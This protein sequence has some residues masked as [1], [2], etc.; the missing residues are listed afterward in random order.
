[1]ESLIFL[2]LYI[3]RFHTLSLSFFLSLQKHLNAIGFHPHSKLWIPPL[4]VLVSAPFPSLSLPTPQIPTFLLS[5]FTLFIKDLF[6]EKHALH[7]H[8]TSHETLTN[9]QS[10]TKIYYQNSYHS[11]SSHFIP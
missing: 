9:G 1:M 8:H 4:S 11:P 10:S 3:K 7:H 2:A 5:A 6:A